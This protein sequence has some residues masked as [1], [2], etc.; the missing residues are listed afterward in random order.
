MASTK[1]AARTTPDAR[2]LPVRADQAL[3]KVLEPIRGS[4]HLPG[5][6]GAV[7]TGNGLAAIGAVGI[8]K[9]GSSEPIQV[10]DQVHIGSCTKAMTATLIGTLVES[11]LLN[12][13]TT[14]RDVFPEVASRLHPDFRSVTLSHLLTHRAG[15]PHDASWWSLPGRTTTEKRRA[16]LTNLMAGPPLSKPGT[17]Y[18]YSNVGY[19]LAGLMTEQLT[20]QSWED[21]MQHR[22]FEPLGMTSAGFGPPGGSGSERIDQPWGHR[23]RGGAVEPARRDNPPCMGPAGTVHCSI[24]DW[25]KFAGLHLRAEQGKARLLKLATFKVLHTPPPG[26]EY[27]GG[28]LVFERSWAGGKALNHSGSNTMWYA[29]VWLA[30]AREFATLVATNQGGDAA[31]AACEEASQELIK[32]AQYSPDGRNR[33]R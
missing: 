11:G 3:N 20:G 23:E 9:I 5:V 19:A 13:S 21:L 15:L 16:A 32:F 4:H 25:A 24:P 14:I 22:L 29:T 31:S 1:D 17:V 7:L 33:R 8:R 12:W 26:Q 18:A 27:A 28:W 6:I 10:T 2:S 30:P